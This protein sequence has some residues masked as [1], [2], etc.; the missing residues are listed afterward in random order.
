MSEKKPNINEE[1]VEA[2]ALA[3]PVDLDEELEDEDY[4]DDEEETYSKNKNDKD[5]DVSRQADIE[6][7]TSELT[8]VDE[9]TVKLVFNTA[10]DTI[11]K[12]LEQGRVVKLHGKGRF[13]LSK[14]SA[15]VG[16]NPLTG[17]EHDVPERE[18]MAFQTSPAF[19]KRLR[20]RREAINN[21]T[22]E[23]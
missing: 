18:A 7:I 9:G 14:R 1:E 6:A 8:G 21:A 17:E 16:R 13:Y 4:D 2:V 15:R 3:T 23:E 20:K 11:C 12:E 22:P 19:A 5:E 10:W